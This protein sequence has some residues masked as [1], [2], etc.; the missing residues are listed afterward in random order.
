MYVVTAS[1]RSTAYM[2]VA[3]QFSTRQAAVNKALTLVGSQPG[4]DVVIR[5]TH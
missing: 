2:Q 1:G 5:R 3:W 4:M